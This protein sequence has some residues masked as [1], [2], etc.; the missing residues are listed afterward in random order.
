MAYY[1]DLFSPETHARFSAS[2]RTIS[3]FRVRQR[4]IAGRVAPGDKLLCYVTRLSRWVGVLEVLSPPFEDAKPIFADTNDPFT[5]RFKVRPLVWLPPEQG[6]P[7]HDDEIWSTLTLT[8]GHSQ[9]TAKWTGFFRGSLNQLTD[10]DGQFLEHRLVGQLATRTSYPLDDQDRKALARLIAKRPEGAVTVTVPDDA[11][12][13]Q[14]ALDRPRESIKVQAALARIGATMGFR[15]W[16]PA[17]DRGGVL[18]EWSGGKTA[19]VDALPLN[20][21]ETTLDTIERIDVLWLKN[22]SIVRAFEVEHTTAIYSGL[23]RMA[24]LISLQPNMSIKLHIVAPESRRSKV[25]REIMRPVF[26]LLEARPLA[27]TCTYL[28]Y[29]SVREIG[30]LPHLAHVNDS[31]LDDFAE[32]AD[33]E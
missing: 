27:E 10:V 28:S 6:L 3:G 12:D 13:E 9:Q 22:R 5:V 32:E 29:D 23:L 30:D 21:D 14:D 26:S 4:K 11:E 17:N 16:V 25:L 33:N 7:I 2:N 1:L 15:I 18:G 24:D 20:Y 8:K 31:V 19:I